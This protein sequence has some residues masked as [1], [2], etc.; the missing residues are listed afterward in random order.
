MPDKYGGTLKQ[1]SEEGLFDK[2]QEEIIKSPDN[3]IPVG[4]VPEAGQQPDDK[5]VEIGAPGAGAV[6]AQRDVYILA[7]P[8]GERDMP[9]PPEL[10]DAFGDIGV[11]E[12]FKKVKAENTAQSDSHVRVSRKVKV[13]LKGICGNAKPGTGHRQLALGQSR[14]VF[15]K[16]AGG[17][18]E[19]H[20]FAEPHGK[21][22]YAGGYQCQRMRPLG[23]LLVDVAVA[24][25]GPGDKLREKC[26][27]GAEVADIFLRAGLAAVHVNDI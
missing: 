1:L 8:G 22:P 27:I 3:E 19:K 15:P 23:Q 12:V 2:E 4:A 16:L 25:D 11:I 24:H 20:L 9:A 18:G 7:E 13:N 6:P 17:V 14:E 10:G 5:K 21:G 26:H